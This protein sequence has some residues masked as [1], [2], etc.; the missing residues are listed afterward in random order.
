PERQS[1]RKITSAPTPCHRWLVEGIEDQRSDDPSDLTSRWLPDGVEQIDAKLN[2]FRRRFK[3][4][5]LFKV[6]N[7][8]LKL[9][10]KAG[11]IVTGR[12]MLLESGF[13]L[14]GSPAVNV[15]HYILNS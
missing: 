1:R 4:R 3:R 5:V 7:Q 10:P 12:Q 13:F 9:L 6:G 14:S 8:S 11:T 2:R 15:T